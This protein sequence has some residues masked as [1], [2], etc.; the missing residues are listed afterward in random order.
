[1]DHGHWIMGMC[2]PLIPF[3][4][5]IWWPITPGGCKSSAVKISEAQSCEMAIDC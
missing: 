2:E 1:V 3:C 4:V 5:C